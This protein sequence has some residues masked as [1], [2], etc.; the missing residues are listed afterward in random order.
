MTVDGCRGAGEDI[1]DDFPVGMRILA[2]DDDPVCLK[3]LEN[4]LSKCQYHVTATNQARVALKMLRGNRDK[5]DLVISDVHMPDMDGFKLLE[6]VGLEMDLP[7]IMLSANGDTRLVMKGV[8]HGACD[9]LVKPV[10]IEE[11]RNIWQ[12]VIRRKKFD[13]KITQSNS[14]GR[15]HHHC[16]SEESG[17]VG[18]QSSASA[19]HHHNEKLNHKRR[20]DEKQEG[21]SDNGEDDEE[22]PS[23]QKKG[24][25]VWRPELHRKFVAAV[26]QLGI[27]KAFP[28]NILDLMNVEGLTRE[29]VASHLQK[30]RLYLK[31]ISLI[32]T[33]YGSIPA[34]FGGKDSA[35]NIRMGSQDGF[36][37]LHTLAAPGQYSHANTF[38]SS[39][40]YSFSRLNTSAGVSLQNLNSLGLLQPSHA[41]TLGNLTLGRLGKLNSNGQ[42]S[43]SSFL[44]TP[45]LE[46]DHAQHSKFTT[47]VL[48]HNQLGNSRLLTAS[49]STCTGS[50]SSM[51]NSINTMLL[52]RNSQYGQKREGLGNPNSLWSDPLSKDASNFLDHG[53]GSNE[54]LQN[55]ALVS[56][57]QSNHPY[58]LTEAF[59]LSSQL[60]K[61]K[62][63]WNYSTADPHSPG[64]P[65][66][67]HSSTA[68]ASMLP[69][70]GTGGLTPNHEALTDNQIPSLLWEE[71]EKNHNLTNGISSSSSG[72]D[73]MPFIIS[74]GV[75]QNYDVFNRRMDTSLIGQPNGGSSVHLQDSRVRSNEDYL[76][77]PAKTLL[78]NGSQGSESFGD[79]MD[80]ILKQDQNGDVLYGEFGLRFDECSYGS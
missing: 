47:S 56:N 33:P 66:L 17:L 21:E 72:N 3:L 44:G 40:P 14:S 8:T 52:Q 45:S 46:L 30:Y 58:L 24:R 48:G 50:G 6:L 16:G 34:V 61:N 80:A 22:D 18:D 20:K 35:Y 36:R 11:L 62:D 67:C 39:S 63:G 23:T 42:S 15:D 55:P 10:R 13:S 26:N 28:K 41:Q 25:V 76:L 19:V 12:H 77:N 43:I 4:M 68:S 29:N 32:Q 38:L 70:E 69:E 51:G 7:V 5:F 65:L 27:E 64:S 54:T 74:Q 79:L 1:R 2:V 71:H 60:S 78:N 49:S 59:G 9:Y 53:G 31:R 57:V 37:D 75:D 73:M